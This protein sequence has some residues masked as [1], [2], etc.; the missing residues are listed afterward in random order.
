MFTLLHVY[1][2]F[3]IIMIV[4]YRIDAAFKQNVICKCYV[5]GIK[6]EIEG[7]LNWRYIF[8]WVFF[9]VS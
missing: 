7:I 1:I 6:V 9:V 5:I 4:K 8:N 2:S 3:V